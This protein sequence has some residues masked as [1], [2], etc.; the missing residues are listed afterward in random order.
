MRTFGSFRWSWTQPVET[1]AA[2][3]AYV[4]D[5]AVGLPGPGGESPPPGSMRAVRE[6]RTSEFQLVGHGLAEGLLDGLD[7]DPVV[8]VGEEPLDDQADGLLALDAAR[9]EV[10]DHLLVHGPGRRAV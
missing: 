8:D 1:R 10:E 9:A 2:G 4:A 6:G 7:R 5:I 3:W